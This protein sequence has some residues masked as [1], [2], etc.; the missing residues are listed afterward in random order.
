M[1]WFQCSLSWMWVHLTTIIPKS[2]AVQNGFYDLLP[3]QKP[4][5]KKKWQCCGT[6]L[7]HFCTISSLD[8]QSYFGYYLP[9]IC[10]HTQEYPLVCT[11]L[12]F[13]CRSI[14]LDNATDLTKTKLLPNLAPKMASLFSGS[15]FRLRLKHH[16][17]YN[18]S[19]LA[20]VV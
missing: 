9:L 11:H 8:H 18:L 4:K 3:C 19:N 13:Q 12:I 14:G 20:L 7:Y 6:G 10:S 2:W 17:V 15:N 5:R 1:T 16:F